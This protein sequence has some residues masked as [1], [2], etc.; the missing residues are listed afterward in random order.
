MEV[1]D[2]VDGYAVIGALGQLLHQFLDAVFAAAVHAGLHSLTHSL[3]IVHLGGRAEEDLFGIPP[4]RPGS[5]GH[6][7]A[8]AGNIF[9]DHDVIT[10]FPSYRFFALTMISSPGHRLET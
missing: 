5:L 3:G 7:L 10:T 1:A 4:G 2:K 8:D 6:L 9:L